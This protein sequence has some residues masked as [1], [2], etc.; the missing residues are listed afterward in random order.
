MGRVKAN[1]TKATG[2]KPEQP[3]GVDAGGVPI[4]IVRAAMAEP[5]IGPRVILSSKRRVPLM[6]GKECAGFVTPHETPSGWRAG[7]IYVV[8]GHRGHHHVEEF[9]RQYPH[10]AWVAF[11]PKGNTAS[12]SLHSRAGF[13][14]WKRSKFGSWY[15]REA[16]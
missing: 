8:P 3:A 12:A 14:P 11:V 9:Y 7:P 2:A 5:L 4:E 1:Q 6:H 13:V 16:T 15:R 10:R